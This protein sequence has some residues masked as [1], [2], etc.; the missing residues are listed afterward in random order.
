MVLGKNA[1]TVLGS[2]AHVRTS[3]T[4]PCAFG[5]PPSLR[6]CKLFAVC[7]ELKMKTSTKHTFPGS[8]FCTSLVYLE[9]KI[10]GD[11]RYFHV[12]QTRVCFPSNYRFLLKWVYFISWLI[13]YY[14]FIYFE[15]ETS[16][17]LIKRLNIVP[18]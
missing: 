8:S 4:L 9:L 15:M 14:H 6:K 11:K 13:I 12:I 18:F 16:S 10:K 2:Q 3:A 1:K 17:S 7:K 5:L